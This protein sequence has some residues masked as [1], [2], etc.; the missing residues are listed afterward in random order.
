MSAALP[1]M[2]Q[3]ALHG[4]L[5]STMHHTKKLTGA[6]VERQTI[7]FLLGKVATHTSHGTYINEMSVS[8]GKKCDKFAVIPDVHAVKFPRGMHKSMTVEQP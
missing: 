4:N 6:H 7:S 1:G 5:E 3:K 8:T 2:R